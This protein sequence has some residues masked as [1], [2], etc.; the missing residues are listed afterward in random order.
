M[1]YNFEQIRNDYQTPPELIK[2]GLFMA[3]RKDMFDLDV[4]CSEKNIPAKKHYILG[5]YDGLTNDWEKLN[6]CNPPFNE[7]QKWVKRAYDEQK[8]GNETIMLIPVRTETAYW[9]NYILFNPNVS[10][11]WLKKGHSFINP[12]TKKPMGIF[13]N[14]L[15]LVHFKSI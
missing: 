14:A 6:W 7:C 8:Y 11:Y 1:K 15:A 3:K 10:I 4:C 12:D 2:L 13:K 9:H 5:E